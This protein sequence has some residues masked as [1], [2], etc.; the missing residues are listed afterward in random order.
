MLAVLKVHLVGGNPWWHEVIGPA[1]IAAT[2]IAAAWI[3]ART[4][5]HRQ[6]EQLDHDRALQTEQLA[7]DREQ[8]ERVFVREVID[9]A[10]KGVDQALRNLSEYSA[11]VLVGNEDRERHRREVTSA[12]PPHH[13]LKPVAALQA[14]RAESDPVHSLDQHLYDVGVDL[15]S[16]ALRLGLRLGEKDKIVVAHQ[17]FAD[18]F[19][20]KHDLLSPL[21]SRLITDEDRTAL[22]TVDVRISQAVASIFSS[23]RQWIEG[24]D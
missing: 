18:E 24:E 9:E 22:D 23:V 11:A 4:A 3:A 7:Y 5:N 16:A 10:M 14:L 17:A 20:A 6:Q 8:R 21:E 1:L 2:A 12:A 19:S 13:R 15:T